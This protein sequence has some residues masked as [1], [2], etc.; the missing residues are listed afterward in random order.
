[1]AD[2]K[3]EFF[4]RSYIV[5]CKD[6]EKDDLTYVAEMLMQKIAEADALLEYRQTEKI[7]IMAALDLL[8]NMVKSKQYLTRKV[9]DISATISET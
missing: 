3:V 7:I 6:E 4:D 2:V 1:M 8:F 9:K 5:S